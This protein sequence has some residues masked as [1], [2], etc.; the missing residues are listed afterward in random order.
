LKS[1]FRSV[2]R[3]MASPIEKILNAYPDM[4]RTGIIV[5]RKDGTF[6]KDGFILTHCYSLEKIDQIWSVN[7]GFNN[8][9]N[10]KRL[11]LSV[12]IDSGFPSER[13]EKLIEELD[14]GFYLDFYR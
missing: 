8:D 11:P 4:P 9:R 6:N 12:L 2:I 5:P 14:S 1:I 10:W 7:V 13:L 3:K